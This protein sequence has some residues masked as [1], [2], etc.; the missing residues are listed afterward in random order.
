[1]AHTPLEDRETTEDDHTHTSIIK[2]KSEKKTKNKERLGGMV[3]R[4]YE[5]VFIFLPR[6]KN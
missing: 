6:K 1:M 4:G 2:Q 5:L 3:N